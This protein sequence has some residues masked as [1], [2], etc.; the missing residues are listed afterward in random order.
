MEVKELAKL[1]G[2]SPAVIA[3][4]IRQDKFPFATGIRSKD[5]KNWQ[6]LI[7]EGKV[8]E[9]ITN[10]SIKYPLSLNDVAKMLNRAPGT[11]ALY[12]QEDKLPFGVAYK[13]DED[14]EKYYYVFF[15][16]K[17]EEFLIGFDKDA[18]NVRKREAG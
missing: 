13:V 1:L 2:S 18:R 7:W 6:Y 3:A 12:A 16:A 5:R 4:G 11:I 8:K 15:P 9:Y 14:N 17:V 10:A